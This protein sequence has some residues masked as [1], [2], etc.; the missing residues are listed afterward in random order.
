MMLRPNVGD[1]TLRFTQPRQA[2]KACLVSFVGRLATWRRQL[3]DGNLATG[4]LATGTLFS[5]KLGYE[6]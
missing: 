2:P 5:G 4:N 3:G 1:H 6:K